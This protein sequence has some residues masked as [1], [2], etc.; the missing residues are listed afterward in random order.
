MIPGCLCPDTSPV[1]PPNAYAGMIGTGSWSG[2][3]H[4]GNW[5]SM[6]GLPI[7]EWLYDHPGTQTVREGNDRAVARGGTSLSTYETA[8]RLPLLPKP[9]PVAVPW[10]SRRGGYS[11]AWH[12]RL[13]ISISRNHG[14]KILRI[15]ARRQAQSGGTR[16]GTCR[17]HRGCP[18]FIGICRGRG[19]SGNTTHLCRS[20]IISNMT[21]SHERAWVAD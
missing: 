5:V 11:M 2:R 19:I 9:P 17:A 20:R 4:R 13:S 21:N 7:D 16:C 18:V 10:A 6:T 15:R 12:V 3:A 1:M 14:C 8:P